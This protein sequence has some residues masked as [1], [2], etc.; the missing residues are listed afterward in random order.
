M[1]GREDSIMKRHKHIQKFITFSVILTGI[2][3][4]MFFFAKRQRKLGNV[5][6]ENPY[7]NSNMQKKYEVST[8][9]LPVYETSVKPLLDKVISFV[10]L[11]ILSPLYLFISIALYLE[12]PGP[13]FFVQTRVGKN[14]HFFSLHKFRSM[15]VSAPHEVP[16]HLLSNPEQ[17]I[18]KVGGILRRTSLDELPQMWDIFCGYMSF[19]GPRP[20]LWNQTDLIAE[21]EKY[22]ANAIL[23]GLTGLAQISGRDELEISDKAKRDGEYTASLHKDSLSGLLQDIKCLVRTIR[24][25][26]KQDG[27]VEGGT[28]DKRDFQI[29][30]GKAAEDF[31]V[32]P[33]EYGNKKSFKIDK[34]TK[35]QVLI[36]GVGSYIGESFKEYAKTYYPN[37]HIDSLDMTDRNWNK[38]DFS[39]YDAV[40]HVAGIA[41]AKTGTFS[42]KEKEK[43]YSVNSELAIET[44][45][46]AKNEGVSQFLFLSS[47]II[48]GNSAPYGKQKVIEE[49]TPPMPADIYGDSKWRGEMGIRRLKNENFHVAVLRLPMVYGKG[50]KGNY[51]LLAKA[52]RWFPVFPKVQNER[53]MIYINN[54]CE[55]ISLLILSGEGGIYFP[56]NSTYSSTSEMLREIA[57]VG[58][59]KLPLWQVLKPVVVLG[60]KLPGRVGKLVRKVFGNSVYSQS[61][62]TYKGLDYQLTE[63]KQ[64]IALTE[65]PKTRVI[66]FLVNH[67]VVI[68]NFRLE[69]VERLLKEGYEIHISSPYGEHIEELKAL[70]AN[71]HEISIDRHGMNPLVEW[72]LLREYRRLIAKIHPMAVLGYTVKPDIYGGI[73]AEEA[74][75]PF[76]AN[77]TG[78]GISVEAGGIKAKLILQLYR[79]GLRKASMVFFQNKENQSFM[80]RN[81]VIS[82]SYD[83]LPGSGVNLSKHCFEEYPKNTDE[84]VFATIG[85]IMK[86]K[87]IIEL[88]EAAKKIKRR[89]PK[90]RFRLIGFFDEDYEKIIKK[91]IEEGFIEYVEQQK[92][93]HPF[94]ASAHAILHPSYHEGMSNVLLE[95]A[96]TGRPVLA[97]RIPGCQEAFLEGVSGLGFKA[98]SSEDIVRAVEEF[99][100]LPYEKKSEM[101]MEGRKRM[102][103]YFD[104]GIV[105]EK[106][107]K[108][109]NK[110]LE[111][112]RNG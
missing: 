109:I 72:S 20:A 44:A 3:N 69:L 54:L 91:A 102:E 59:K 83:L 73:A 49:D 50:S 66:L 19:I 12:D 75:I 8:S 88:L 79:R 5:E 61:L 92:E 4:L 76:I 22:G 70:G 53:S 33:E 24:A 64:S 7:L 46:K 65:K 1:V 37:L 101:G 34:K 31:K 9:K 107:M 16:T 41:H 96:A 82:S 26:A 93:I 78:L 81:K 63:L 84:L 103:Q 98:K 112:Q 2:Y 86:D 32:R 60:N 52:A 108:K 111:E 110:I 77:I 42:K 43:Y 89:Y 105:V 56:Q 29:M 39:F 106:Y 25:V 45:Q 40:L 10:G 90:V 68:Y 85:R 57:A 104:R 80:L 11:V 67:D 58:G 47:M 18:T 23:P 13:I 35:K 55:F 62:S 100:R 27:V 51:P 95:A 48:Y 21:R 17:Y 15:K 94:I 28:G 87:G 30:Q 14:M 74:G 99:I 38:Y 97:S 71:Y 36:T 6:R